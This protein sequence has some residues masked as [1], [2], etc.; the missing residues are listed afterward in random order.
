MCGL[1]KGAGKENPKTEGR[2]PNKERPDP[3][4][5]RGEI[6]ASILET[7]KYTKHTK[8]GGSF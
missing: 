5:K 8:S 1:C 2:R 6:I 4:R 3:C 7:T